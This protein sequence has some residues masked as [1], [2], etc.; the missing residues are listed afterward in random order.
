M[1]G[2]QIPF[3]WLAPSSGIRTLESFLSHLVKHIFVTV[4]FK[5]PIPTHP[6]RK[7]R[8]HVNIEEHTGHGFLQSEDLVDRL[9]VDCLVGGDGDSVHYPH[10]LDPDV[11]R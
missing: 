5:M 9:E 11:H 8:L 10:R 6:L 7:Q 2:K 4:L 1:K 3:G